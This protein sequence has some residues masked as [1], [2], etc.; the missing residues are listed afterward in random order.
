MTACRKGLNVYIE[1]CGPMVVG[2]PL[3][4][5]PPIIAPCPQLLRNNREPKWFRYLL[6]RARSGFESQSAAMPPM[7]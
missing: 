6:L 2:Y 5:E 3:Q 4:S 7:A 1:S